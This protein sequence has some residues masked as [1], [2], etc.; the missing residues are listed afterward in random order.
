MSERIAAAVREQPRRGAGFAVVVLVAL[1]AAVVLLVS[2]LS[3]ASG[4]APKR[5]RVHR[6]GNGA[7]PL[8]AAQ[9][10]ANV[11]RLLGEM[12]VK[13]KFGQLEMAGPDGPNGTPG[14]LTT[15]A[16]H[17]E[18]GTVLDLVGV[19]N[20]NQVQDAALSSR[21]HIPLLFGLDV[22]HGYPLRVRPR[23]SPSRSARRTSASTT[24]RGSSWSRRARSTC[25][26]ATARLGSATARR[27]RSTRRST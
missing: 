26:S 27:E 23:P 18:I 21:L 7:T 14:S 9:I 3:T 24:S 6:A 4:A 1:I 15:L 20:I 22:I 11:N 5:A 12:T 16:R 10:N 17:G 2:G 19:D 13:E 25:G 8:S